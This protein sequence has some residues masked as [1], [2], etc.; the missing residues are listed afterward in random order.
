MDA[1][2]ELNFRDGAV[3]W[4]L[5]L[6]V[7]LALFLVH[8]DRQRRKLA[9]RFMSERVRGQLLPG[10]SLRPLLLTFGIGCLIVAL[11]GPQF[12]A[13]EQTI[14]TPEASLVVLLDTSLSMAASDVGTS[15]LSAARA[16][17]QKVLASYDGRAGLIVFEGNAEVISPLTNDTMAIAS[18]LESVGVAELEV[19]GSNLRLAITAG[20]ELL[21]RSNAAS[22]AMLLISDGEHRAEELRDVLARVRERGVPVVTVMIGTT[23][24][25][26]VP[27]ADGTPLEIEG[28]MVVT[29]ARE[30]VL[31]GIARETDARFIANPFSEG[32]VAQLVEAVEE[33]AFV[34]ET[35]STVRVPKNRYQIPLSLALLFFIAGSLLNRG[36][37]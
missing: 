11:A 33:H 14:E 16:V 31:A 21:D 18:L 6:L 28:E 1:F 3:L 23:E 12:G 24:G 29:R 34:T 19:S 36:A 9:N 2:A 15:R 5:V 20:L 17:I 7:P 10:R 22:A 32:A 8:R 26:T 25:S 30:D 37:E 35:E 4:A 13:A 27:T